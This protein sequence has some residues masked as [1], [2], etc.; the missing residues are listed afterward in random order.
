MPV[1]EATP[2]EQGESGGDGTPPVCTYVEQLAAQGEGIFP[3]EPRGRVLALIAENQKAAVQARAQG[4]AQGDERTGRQPT[5]VR[6]Q[7]GGRRL[8]LSYPGRRPAGE[9]LDARLT[10]REPGRGQPVVLSAA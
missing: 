3:E 2:G 8:G 4:K 9:N 1:P 6:V 7:V 10:K 5:A